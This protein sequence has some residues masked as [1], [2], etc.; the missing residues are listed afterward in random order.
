MWTDTAEL[1][2]LTASAL[3]V[4]IAAAVRSTWSPCGLSM[5]STITPVSERAKGNTYRWTATW[6]TLG[7]T[8]GGAS[9]G[10][11][12]GGLAWIVRWL[13]VGPTILG[14]VGVV[15][16]LVAATSDLGTV[17]RR[18]PFHGRQVNERWLDQYRSWVY[19]AG[20]GWQIGC[21]LATYITTAGVYLMIVLAALSAS[22]TIA[23]VVGTLFGAV[24]GL[25]VFLT[26][27]VSGSAELLAFHRRFAARERTAARAVV[28]AELVAAAIIT[29][30]VWS[31]SGVSS[32]AGIVCACAVAVVV[33][34]AAFDRSRRTHERRGA[35]TTAD[36]RRGHEADDRQDLERT[37]AHVP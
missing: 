21:G 13:N 10:A 2:T 27:N 4:A 23:I 17:G 28:V 37:A 35:R 20:F 25:A 16:A 8:V 32:V 26:R 14:S 15:A 36:L 5:L 34:T 3:L 29:L 6:F 22:P 11:L 18:L 7:A 19:G 9:V 24:R 1:A 31:L 12:A 30:L 33:G